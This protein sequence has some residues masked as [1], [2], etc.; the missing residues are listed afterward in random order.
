MADVKFSKRNGYRAVRFTMRSNT[1]RLLSVCVIE[2]ARGL[3]VESI[4]NAETG[5][6]VARVTF[7]RHEASAANM[8]SVLFNP[9]SDLY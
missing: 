1:N 2:L 6:S 8:A 7:E 3:R 5:K 4:A 9:V